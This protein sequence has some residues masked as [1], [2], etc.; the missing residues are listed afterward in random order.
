MNLE[1]L[2]YLSITIEA[3]I[4]IFGLMIVSNKKKK[5]GWGIFLTFAIYV[6]YDFARL[7]EWNINQNLLYASFFIATLS[8]LL[9]VLKIYKK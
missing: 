8:M 1:F 9:V 3:V 7:L 6:I 4:A 5:L 2:Q